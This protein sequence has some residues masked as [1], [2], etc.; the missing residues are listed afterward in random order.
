MHQSSNDIDDLDEDFV[1]KSELKREMLKL[2]DLAS[3]LI[4]FSKHQRSKLPLTQ[5]LQDAMLLADKIK[6][7]HEALRRH[8][9]YVARLLDNTDLAPIQQAL[10][11]LSNK[12]QQETMK[13]HQLEQLRE[14]LLSQ[15]NDEIEALLNEQSTLDR[16]KLRQL[17]RATIKEQQAEKPPKYYRELFQ[18]LKENIQF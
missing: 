17:I 11:L 4:K 9:R 15:D 10:D 8:V 7:K 18:Y 3:Q 16:Q 12:H 2:Q 5:E 14:Q 13:F 6:N 1:S